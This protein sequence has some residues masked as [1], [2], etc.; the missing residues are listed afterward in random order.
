M[1]AALTASQIP[2]VKA[3]VKEVAPTVTAQHTRR[4]LE[5][6]TSDHSL[7]LGN[8]QARPGACVRGETTGWHYVQVSTR[9]CSRPRFKAGFEGSPGLFNPK[10]RC[11]PAPEPGG[12]GWSVD[13]E[14][15]GEALR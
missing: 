11:V 10:K 2:N 9:S 15:S 1:A 4:P 13:V 7:R 6:T 8:G 3:N 5:T 14:V 12:S